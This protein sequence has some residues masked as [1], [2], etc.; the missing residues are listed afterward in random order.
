MAHATGI[1]VIFSAGQT[2][3]YVWHHWIYI[4]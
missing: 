2:W 3:Y 1:I 4:L